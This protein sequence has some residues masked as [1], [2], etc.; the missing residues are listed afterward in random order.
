MGELPV[1]KQLYAD[2]NIQIFNMKKLLALL[3]LSPFI[4]SEEIEYPVEL[5]CE[6]GSSIMWINLDENDSYY[7]LLSNESYYESFPNK[8]NNTDELMRFKNITIQ[9]DVIILKLIF[10]FSNLYINRYSLK[11]SF[12]GS[13]RLF[14]SDRPD[15]QCYKGFKEYTQKQI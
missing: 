8:L 2:L 7:F 1:L 15:G 9:D 12:V 13:T 11:A 6:I 10:A 5:T 4:I 14:P 3:L